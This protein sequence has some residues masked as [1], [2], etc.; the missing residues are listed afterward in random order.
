MKKILAMCALAFA[1][2]GSAANAAL[3]EDFDGGGNTPFNLTNSG[4]GAPA[5][6]AGGPDGNFVR[7]TNLNG[8][9]NNSIAFDRNPS[10]SGSTNN[11]IRMN[12]D[13][14][15][16]DNAANANAGGCCGSAADGL[17]IG[18]FQTSTYGATGGVNPS[19]L[20]GGAWERP[21]FA[22]AFAIGMDIFSNIDVVTLNFNGAEVAAADVRSFL[23][24]NSNLFHRTN[25]EIH[26]AGGGNAL[27]DMTIIEDVHGIAVAHTIF[28]QQ[29]VTGLDLQ[30]L[31]DYRVIAG[32][33]TG[34]AFTAG[35]FDNISVSAV[36][37]PTTAALGLL[38]IFGMVARRRRTA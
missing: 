32:G 8:S 6:L 33:R 19:T 35:D 37:E 20:V 1:L 22:D 4:G 5:V 3:V 14:R 11:F 31:G 17:G 23:D 21:R 12:Y 9:N 26:N 30:N 27:V 13:F 2:M 24:L 16:T 38:G 25:V 10:A 18:L 29:L 28:S 36:P 34:G 7:I 15:M